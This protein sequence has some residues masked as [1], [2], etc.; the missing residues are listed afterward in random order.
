MA[1]PLRAF[2]ATLASPTLPCIISS[3][4]STR[5]LVGAGFD[6]RE[7]RGSDQFRCIDLAT[8]AHPTTGYCANDVATS[9]VKKWCMPP[10]R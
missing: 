8:G 1:V 4:S 9:S 3:Q 7:F 5:E 10:C 6:R 2:A